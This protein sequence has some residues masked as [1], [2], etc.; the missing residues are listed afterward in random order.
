MSFGKHFDRFQKTG[1]LEKEHHIP[2]EFERLYEKYA[3]GLIFYARKFVDNSTA[4][5]TVH[6]VFLKIWN[7]ET[8]PLV[9]ESVGSYLFRAV[10]NSCLDYLKHRTV[11]NDYLSKA[12]RDLKMEELTSGESLV[13]RLTDREQVDAVYKAID[14]LPEKCREIFVLAY[15]DERK[16]AEIAEQFHISVRTVEAQIY[17]ALKMLRNTLKAIWC[18]NGNAD[19]TKS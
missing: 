3:P 6:D 17:K 11:C 14:Q 1:K 18:E 5:D 13:N 12:V 10:R 8:V 7:R 15:V 4:E 2:A 9:G 16:N 19:P